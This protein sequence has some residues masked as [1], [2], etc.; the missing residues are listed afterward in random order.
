MYTPHACGLDMYTVSLYFVYYVNNWKKA[1][2][3]RGYCEKDA[4]VQ[5]E[6]SVGVRVIM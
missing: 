6:L 4:A 3:G 5:V 1:M 2:R